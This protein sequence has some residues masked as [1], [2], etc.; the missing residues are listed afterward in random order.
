MKIVLIAPIPKEG[1]QIETKIVLIA[2]VP[3]EGD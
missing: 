2:P 3:K 1:D